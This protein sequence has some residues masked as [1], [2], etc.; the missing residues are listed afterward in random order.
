MDVFKLNSEFFSL[1]CLKGVK[2][3]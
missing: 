2:Q 1:F 3:H